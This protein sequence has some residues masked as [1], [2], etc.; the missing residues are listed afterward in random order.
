M[1]TAA[2]R[3]CL[4]GSILFA[5]PALVHASLEY[6]V[7][8]ESADLFR[9]QAMEP[10][11]VT[12]LSQGEVLKLIRKGESGS[13]VETAGGIQAWIHNEDL[14]A[15]ESAKGQ[16]FGLGEQS[17]KGSELNISPDTWIPRFD[18]AEVVPLDR[19]FDGEIIQVLDKEAVE[20]KNGDN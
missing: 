15:M 12:S 3:Y 4:S 14:L 10:P 7:K 19:T 13:L 20:M 5:L 16:K 9:T 2:L 18:P 8:T 6:S 1:R 17:V 11:P